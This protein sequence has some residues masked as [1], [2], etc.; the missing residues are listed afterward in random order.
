MA[1]VRPVIK[2]LCVF[3]FYLLFAGNVCEAQNV[4][5]AK[6]EVAK[7]QKAMSFNS[8]QAST[9]SSLSDTCNATLL[10]HLR[11]LQHRADIYDVESTNDGGSISVGR[12]TNNEPFVM[13]LTAQGSLAW[14]RTYKIATTEYLTFK[15]ILPTNDSN[16]LLLGI[17]NVQV[18]PFGTNNRSVLVKMNSNGDTLW[19]RKYDYGNTDL[20]IYSVIPVADGDFLAC[21]NSNWGT[22]NT[23]TFLMRLTSTGGI[24]WK[25]RIVHQQPGSPTYKNMHLEGNDLYLLADYGQTPYYFTVERWDAVSG[26]LIWNKRLSV[27]IT[28]KV[29]AG[30]ITKIGDTVYALLS[31]QAPTV[32]TPGFICMRT[33]V[34]R[35]TAVGNYLSS[36]R[37]EM[38]ENTS[39]GYHQPL[40][41]HLPWPI[42][43]T[44]DN[45]FLVAH[46]RY[47]GISTGLAITKMT[48]G[49]IPLWSET[50]PW[51][52]NHMVFSVKN[53]GT[54]LLVAGRII[55][56]TTDQNLFVSYLMKTDP[57][58][59]LTPV[60]SAS[61]CSSGPTAKFT[62]PYTSVTAIAGD[63]DAIA[64]ADL[65]TELPSSLIAMPLDFVLSRQC[66]TVSACQSA[67]I[68]GP[69][70]ICNSS[71]PVIFQ[72][73]RNAGCTT[74]ATFV[75]DT[76]AMLVV[77]RTDSTMAVL[78]K[79][80]GI[81]QVA[82][83]IENGCT[84]LKATKQVVVTRNAASLS[85]GRDTSLCPGN[86]IALNGGSGFL[87]YRWLDGSSDSAL[88]V[89][90]P[91]IYYL[92]VQDACGNTTRDSVL[93][94]PQP[95]VSFAVSADRTKCNNDTL[96]FEAPAGFLSYSWSPGY[97][98]SSTSLPGVVVNP[99]VDTTYYIKAEKTPGCFA[100]DTIRVNVFHSPVIDLGPDVNFC[101]GDSVTFNADSGFVKY[102]W[103]NTNGG[104]FYTTYSA[105]T[106]TVAATTTGGCQSY[107]TVRVVNVWPLPTVKLDKTPVLCEG[108]TRT[109]SPG[110]FASYL[111]QNGSNAATFT[112]T[113]MGRYWVKVTDNNGCPGSDTTDL[114][115]VLP[116][117]VGFLPGDSTICINESLLLQPLQNYYD[118]SWSNGS[119][120]PSIVIDKPGLYWLKVSDNNGC[121]GRDTVNIIP[122]QCQ[123]GV[124]I[125]TAFTPNRDGKNDEFRAQV[126]GSIK[127]FALLL[128]NRWGQVVFQST[129]PAQGW[130]GK[131]NGLP[132]ATGVYIWTCTYQL[133]GEA[134]QVQKGTFT[135]I[136]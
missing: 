127:K 77:N 114:T 65:L 7:K 118:Y 45:N 21:A 98:I 22:G 63:V 103:N 73:N 135:I 102:A 136:R 92:D 125:P 61:A 79:R 19:T 20:D 122:R 66:S 133:E 130:D 15:K 88:M 4:I 29:N 75:V 17:N 44:Q 119:R 90:Q 26:Q 109:L 108:T 42:L 117:P 53:A 51:L 24:R 57:K 85:L 58:G 28:T 67:T 30:L 71:V 128:Y 80:T 48:P 33:L 107:D 111:W 18:T 40:S 129:N 62:S 14:S 83:V 5:P 72:V 60:I 69:D 110:A 106:Y 35:F 99:A 3:F 82:F 74:P 116:L 101:S 52:Q 104:P 2:L 46:N 12:L 34:C 55:Q 56:N 91:G 93:V 54:N 124:Y 41:E 112:V 50:Y 97:N 37:V 84:N 39:L 134:E 132:Q 31:Q 32:I 25:K 96:H 100:Y 10:L 1:F 27:D 8:R 49:G 78:F 86:A 23:L 70:T 11:T 64:A 126:F 81:T 94:N 6:K 16:F 76:S 68:S 113:G 120:S 87:S 9:P 115:A 105:G 123:L 13:K 36:Y 131:V 89:T 38:P 47:T 121:E 95:A 43:E 59:K